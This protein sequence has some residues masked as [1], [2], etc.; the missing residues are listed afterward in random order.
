LRGHGK[1]PGDPEVASFDV[2]G[3]K[4]TIEDM[5]LFYLEL[6]RRL[7]D[8]PRYMLGCSLGSFL[9]REYLSKYPN[10]LSGAIIAGTGHQPGWLLSIM[11]PLHVLRLI[12]STIIF[13]VSLVRICMGIGQVQDYIFLVFTAIM[14][15]DDIRKM[16]EWH[17]KGKKEKTADA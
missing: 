7:P 2:D 15:P 12:L 1:N 13:V 17:K 10:G 11:K 3:W 16:I 5:R 6:Q 9:L 8:T 14:L 4:A